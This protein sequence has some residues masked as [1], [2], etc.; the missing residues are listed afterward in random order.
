MLLQLFK[1]GISQINSSSFYVREIHLHT[2]W[3]SEY[4]TSLV[5]ELLKRGWMPNDLVFECRLNTGHMDTILL[6]FVLV[7]YSNVSSI[8]MF[9]V[10]KCSVFRSPLYNEDSNTAICMLDPGVA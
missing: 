10:F 5:F 9:P 6:P 1:L 3:G 8:Q 4:Q 7:W 2:Q